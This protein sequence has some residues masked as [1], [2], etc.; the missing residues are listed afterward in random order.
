ML[1]ALLPVKYCIAAPREA[2]GTSRRSACRPLPSRT[3]LLVGPW[4]RTRSTRPNDDEVIHHLGPGT[5]REDVEVAAGLGAAPQAAD[6][7]EAGVRAGGPQVRDQRMRLLPH[8]RRQV[9]SGKGLMVLDGLAERRFLARAHALD[10]ANGA[11]SRA[12]A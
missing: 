1:W 12:P 5:G 4:P 6:E 9:A 7:I 3:L 2:G 11:R 10:A 8:L